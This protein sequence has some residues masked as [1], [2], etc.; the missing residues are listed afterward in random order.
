MTTGLV[1]LNQSRVVPGDSTSAQP[2]VKAPQVM[3]MSMA[4]SLAENILRH[5]RLASVTRDLI[6]LL[7][8]KPAGESRPGASIRGLP[9]EHARPACH[10][11][12]A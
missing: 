4:S 3:R 5:C 10:P 12:L 2:E 8:V 6:S 1:K 11:L 7:I 9:L